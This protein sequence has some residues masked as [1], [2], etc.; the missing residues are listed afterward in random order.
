MSDLLR[1]VSDPNLFSKIARNYA[2]HNTQSKWWEE[3][4]R[5]LEQNSSKLEQD[6]RQ[7]ELALGELGRIKFPFHEMG[8]IN[9]THLF[10]LHELILLSFYWRNRARYATVADLGANIGLHS[11]VLGILGFNVIAF[12]PDPEHFRVLGRNLVDNGIKS[13]QAV[14][15]AVATSRADLDFIRLLGNTTGSHVAGAKSDPYGP[16]QKIKVKAEDIASV[17]LSADLVKMDVEGLEAVLIEALCNRDFPECDILLEIGTEEN[18]CL[19]WDSISRM[20]D[21]RLYSQK[22]S[23][24]Q[25]RAPDDL[26]HSHREGSALISRRLEA[27]W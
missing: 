24:G 3:S 27:P 20:E 11:V 23:W 2:F 18:A 15:K 4:S 9:S 14:E 22:I 5:L 16:T 25:V 19:I 6:L 7:G 13:V 8:A 17:A 10:G 21:T 12:E 1:T 26:P